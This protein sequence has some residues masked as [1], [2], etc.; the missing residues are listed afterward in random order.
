VVDTDSYCRVQYLFGVAFDMNKIYEGPSLE[1]E[2]YQERE[3]RHKKTMTDI[4]YQIQ[5]TE[6]NVSIFL[7][8]VLV[9]I[10]LA[11]KYA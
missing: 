7:F 4:N 8:M 6:R 10:V 2:K 1:Y 5:A 9:I 3:K 11:F